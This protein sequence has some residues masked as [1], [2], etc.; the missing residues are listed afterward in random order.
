MIFGKY[1]KRQDVR[2]MLIPNK[3]L[4]N[5]YAKNPGVVAKSFVKQGEQVAKGQLLYLISTEQHTLSEQGAVE[6]Q[7]KLLEK[8][9]ALQEDKL[10]TEC[11]FQVCL[12]PGFLLYGPL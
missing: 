7:V 3:G 4:I 11:L 2:G 12:K 6:Q 10:K 9:I 1:A 8:Q 5:V